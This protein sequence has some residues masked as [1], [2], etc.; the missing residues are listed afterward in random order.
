M[1]EAVKAFW[2]HYTPLIE[3][4]TLDQAR[5]IVSNSDAMSPREIAEHLR[6]LG[7]LNFS[8]HETNDHPIGMMLLKVAT[9][10][11]EENRAR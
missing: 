10:K 3:A 8:W 2:A 11:L 6:V 7:Q 1:D 4:I 5:D 9:R